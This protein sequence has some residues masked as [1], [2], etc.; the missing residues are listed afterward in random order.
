[1]V[2]NET[3]QIQQL[4]GIY[5]QGFE[6]VLR[7]IIE[8]DAKG[9]WTRYHK[10]LMLGIQA[11]LRQLDEHA[12]QWIAQTVWQSYSQATADTAAFLRILSVA[13]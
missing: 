6:E 3:E 7:I 11:V 12:D 8:K 9:Q 5:R 1:M 2:F 10:D 4:I 13:A